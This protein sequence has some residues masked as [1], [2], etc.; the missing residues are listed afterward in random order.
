MIV[1]DVMTPNPITVREAASIQEAARLLSR[2]RIS[3]MPVVNE[4]GKMV[5][6]LSEFDILGRP[7]HTVAEVM[8]KGVISVSSETALDMVSH[9]LTD[10]R[11]RRLP[12]VDGNELVG[13]ISRSDIVRAMAV[14]WHCEVCGELIRGEQAPSQCSKCGADA[15]FVHAMPAPGM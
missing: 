8:T 14:F 5:G 11:I 1:R 10:H 2:H 6:I 4:V 15:T 13:I 7:G 9:L 12:V 3:G